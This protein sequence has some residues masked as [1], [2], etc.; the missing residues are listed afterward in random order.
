MDPLVLMLVN[1]QD[2]RYPY[3]RTPY[4]P[5]LYIWTATTRKIVESPQSG[6]QA[7][8]CPY[9]VI[10]ITSRAWVR[11]TDGDVLTR[12]GLTARAAPPRG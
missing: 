2:S 4:Y 6:C 8:E 11:E 5:D 9:R 10:S 1:S 3:G 12:A 7:R